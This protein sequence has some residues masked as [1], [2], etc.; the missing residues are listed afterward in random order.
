MQLEIY[1]PTQEQNLP[2]VSWNFDELK[3]WV[4]EGLSRYRGRVYT[5]A[6]IK[7]AKRDAANLRKL[8]TAINGRRMDIKNQYLEPYEKFAAQ[9]KELDAMLDEQIGEIAAQINAFDEARKAEKREHIRAKYLEIFGDLVPLVPFEKV[10]K[11]FY[12]NKTTKMGGIEDDLADRAARIRQELASIAALSLPV[13]LEA[14]I[15]SV[16]L[17]KLDLSAALAEKA[18]IE[19]EQQ[20]LADYEAAQK[21]A[22]EVP[23]S[24]PHEA[25]G[26]AEDEKLDLVTVDFRIHATREQLAAL[27]AFLV[28]HGID[29]APVPKR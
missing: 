16:Y 12:L 26:Y 24:V 21:K 15:K 6:D 20:A 8:K 11:D 10:C 4:L 2:Q 9:V 18:R 23:Q 27:K 5:E 29:Y 28:E 25:L 17:D 14:R 1:S 7:D 19:Q 22:A 3:A 13:D